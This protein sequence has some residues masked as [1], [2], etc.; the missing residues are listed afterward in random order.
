MPPHRRAWMIAVGL[1]L[2][3]GHVPYGCVLF[4]R[5]IAA[6]GVQRPVFPATRAVHV[7]VA[8]R[9]RARVA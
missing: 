2:H 5:T 8:L 4:D 3:L 9:G 6:L 7:M 1:G